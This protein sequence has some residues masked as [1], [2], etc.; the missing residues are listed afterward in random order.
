MVR[1]LS[2]HFS[3]EWSFCKDQW[4][5]PF[6]YSF[7]FCIVRYDSHQLRRQLASIVVEATFNCNV[8]KGFILH[9]HR[10]TFDS[11]CTRPFLL[12][13][14]S[15][16]KTVTIDCH[17]SFFSD[18]FCQFYWESV[19]IIK[20]K[21]IL[22]SNHCLTFG[23]QVFNN[24]LGKVLTRVQGTSKWFFFTLD[25]FFD[26]IAFFKYF[27]VV[28]FHDLP[29]GW[30]QFIQEGSF[31]PQFLTMH[32]ST[33]EETTKNVTASF[34]TWKSPITNRKWKRTDV[35]S[36]HLEAHVIAI[37][38][39]GL[40]R[41]LFHFTDDW[42]EEVCFKV[43]LRSLDNGYQT[44][45]TSAR[46]NVL[47]WQ[48][49]VFATRNSRVCV[50]L[51]QD[52]VPDF[53]V[54]VVFDIFCKQTKTD[55]FWVK[56]FSTVEEDF[57]IWSRRPCT[58]FPEVVFDWDQVT[59]IHPNSDPTVVWIL[60]IRVIGHVKF[61]FREIKPFRTSQK[62]I[63]PSNGFITEVISDWEIPQHFKHSMVTSS[64][65]YVFDII[66]TNSFL[67]IGNPWIFRFDGSIEVFFKSGNPWVDP[68]K[69]WIVY[70]NQANRWFYWVAFACPEIK[71]HL[72]DLCTR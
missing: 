38:I 32:G 10:S 4:C 26:K 37:W 50:K 35:V 2:T 23:F 25:D 46:I 67:S 31:D 63:S 18:F 16:F 6:R 62:F 39:I 68:Q 34:I 72:T 41:H 51:W 5:S 17:S 52:N 61:V 19:C 65:P 28:A 7:Y 30:N 13:L 11:R 21:D 9:P 36:N 33:T 57:C 1:N 53:D 70:W 56:F 48:F 58:D 3:I 14:H 8:L 55:V 54:T 45:Q 64:L 40:T 12:F 24:G 15:C 22:T 47:V 66:G 43:G 71:P 59:W 20:F 27:W 29:N 44:F 49:L 69:C 60:V 42:H